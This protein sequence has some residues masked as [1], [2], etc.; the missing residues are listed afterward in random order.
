MPGVGLKDP[1]LAVHARLPIRIIGRDCDSA[2]RRRGIC[3]GVRILL[4]ILAVL[5]GP[6]CHFSRPPEFVRTFCCAGLQ[7]RLLI[8]PLS[9]WFTFGHLLVS[10]QLG[11]WCTIEGMTKMGI[12]KAVRAPDPS[13]VDRFS[14]R[15]NDSWPSPEELAGKAPLV[16]PETCWTTDKA[17]ADVGSRLVIRYARFCLCFWL[18]LPFHHGH[19]S[20]VRCLESPDNASP[21]LA[22]AC[23]VPWRHPRCP[24]LRCTRRWRISDNDHLPA[25]GSRQAVSLADKDGRAVTVTASRDLQPASAYGQS[26]HLRLRQGRPSL[27]PRRACPRCPKSGN[28]VLHQPK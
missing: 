16:L 23:P 22:S 24:G 13:G 17:T 2:I 14:N 28:A 25:G 12:S 9:L 20:W 27:P 10:S 3:S 18:A 7:A 5:A 11:P 26:A 6:S 8:A 15:V 1:G 19:P 21:E 4:V